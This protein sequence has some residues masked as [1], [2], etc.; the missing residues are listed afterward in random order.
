MK[1]G[2]TMINEHNSKVELVWGN[3]ILD[4]G[5]LVLPNMLV[6]YARKLGLTYGQIHLINVIFTYKHDT[7][8]PYPSQELIAEHM[9]ITTRQVRKLIESIEE[10]GFV[11]VGQRCTSEGKFLSNIYNFKPLIDKCIE[12][13]Q[14]HPIE[15]PE[16]ESIRWKKSKKTVGTKCT[17][18]KKP[19][20]GTKCTDDSTQNLPTDTTQKVPTKIT[21]K[22]N[23][24]KDKEEEEALPNPFRFY[25]ENGFGMIGG[26]IA[27]KINY[28]LDSN[29]FD[30]PEAIVVEAMKLALENNAKNWKYTETILRNWTEKKAKSLNDV[31]ALV[32]EFN[33][34]KTKNNSLHR[35]NRKNVRKDKLP[36]W[37]S[38]ESKKENNVQESP[39]ESVEF[40][41]KKKNFE[42]MLKK[43]MQEK[44]LG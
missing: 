43:R 38:E 18:G 1:G 14:K 23:N 34:K 25:E 16:E 29:L 19:S 40:E 33:Q 37:L 24:I 10:K 27:E 7:R 41:Q 31:Q 2:V 11:L 12:L 44:Q 20:D 17:D 5:F 4:D 13:N 30:T 39:G 26:H 8:D 36:K 15:T 28:W 21:I 6:R 35:N 3:E 9:D 22:N 32:A 42:E